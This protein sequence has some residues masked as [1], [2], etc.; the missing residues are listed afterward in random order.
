MALMARLLLLLVVLALFAQGALAA[1]GTTPPKPKSPLK[2]PSKP[3]PKPS[4]K[5]PA[6][7]KK[8]ARPASL[9]GCTAKQA[10][11][12]KQKTRVCADAAS[13][14]CAL[15]AAATYPKG[16]EGGPGVGRR[17]LGLE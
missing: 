15:R 7:K 13:R 3:S 9:R 12:E 4:P 10:R 8:R 1:N 11:R 14:S 5:P 17:M 16:V 6:S 2:T